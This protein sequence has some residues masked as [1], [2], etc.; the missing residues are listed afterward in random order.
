MHLALTPALCN[1]LAQIRQPKIGTV[2]FDQF[3]FSILAQTS[4]FLTGQAN[5]I[6]FCFRY[7]PG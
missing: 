4:A 7:W 2:A 1:F 3:L 6:N 5:S